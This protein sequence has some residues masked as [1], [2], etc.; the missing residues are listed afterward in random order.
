MLFIL[1]I[2]DL[3]EQVQ[4]YCKLF[5]DDAK[6]YKDLHNLQDFET[7]QT[8]L[9]KLCEWTSKWLMYFNIDK[10]K[11]MHFGKENP[12]F[13]YEMTDKSGKVR[14]LTVVDSEKDLGIHL[15]LDLKFRKHISF[16]VNRAN[17]LVGLIKRSFSYLN[18]ET[19]LILS[20]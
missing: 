3:P 15:E 11:V 5:A 8:D 1:Y 18:K 4:S 2:N 14:K 7:I 17:R 10:C 20:I 12:Y 16:M 13:D 19:L 9:D 6:L